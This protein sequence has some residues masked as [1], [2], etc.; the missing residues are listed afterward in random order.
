MCRLPAVSRR[1][2]ARPPLRLSVVMA[3]PFAS[4]PL[5]AFSQPYTTCTS[6]PATDKAFPSETLRKPL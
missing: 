2:L 3:A 5:G 6:P 4:R 1:S